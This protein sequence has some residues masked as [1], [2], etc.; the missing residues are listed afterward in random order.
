[1]LTVAASALLLL[2][3]LLLLLLL[4]RLLLLRLPLLRLLLLL[5]RLCCVNATLSCPSKPA[6]HGTLPQAPLL[7][8]H[9][10]YIINSPQSFNDLDVDTLLAEALLG[11]AGGAVGGFLTVP[12]DV[13]TIR[14]LTQG[15]G[16]QACDEET[17]DV[18]VGFLAMAQQ[19]WAEGGLTALFTGW[20]ARTFYWAPAIGIFL[21]CYCSVRQQALAQDIFPVP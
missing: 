13:I 18:P 15:T 12:L 21:S 20:R 8:L 3:L 11:A 7:R 16:E 2:R 1:M 4:L 14:I 6:A 9:N 17:C 5:L 19:I 10:R